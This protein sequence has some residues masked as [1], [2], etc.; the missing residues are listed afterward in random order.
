MIRRFFTGLRGKLILTYTLVTV[1]AL[2]ALEVLAILVVFVPAYLITIDRQQYFSD[3]VDVLYPQARAYLQPGKEDLPG[4]Q[5]W[6]DATYQAGYAS[7][8]AQ[9]ANDSPAAAIVKSDPMVVISPKGIVLAQ[10]PAG[11]ASLVGRQYTPPNT[12]RSQEVLQAALDKNYTTANLYTQTSNGNYLIAVPV[13]AT[14]KQS[15]LVGVIIMTVKPP[16]SLLSTRWPFLA[17]SLPLLVAIVLGTG[18]LLL[19][20]VAPF[21]ALFG[22][23]VSGGLT[24]RLKALTRAADAWSEG[25][26][27][28]QPQ[29]RSQ[30]EIGILGRQMRRMA[31]RVQLLLQSQHE[32]ALMEERNRLARELHDTVKQE[33][34]A[35]LM[36]V[37]AARNL[38]ESD[39]TTARQHLEEAEGL[40]KSSQQELGLI[41]SELRPAALE[42]CGLADALRAYADTWSKHTRIPIEFQVQNECRLSLDAEQAL[43]RIA[44]EALSNVARHSRASAAQLRLEFCPGETQ[45]T[46]SDNGTGFDTNSP[47]AGLGLKSMHERLSTLGGDLQVFSSKEKGTTVKAVLPAEK[48]K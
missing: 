45:L 44:Q 12:S 28:V 33:T 46:I 11:Q 27:T 22:L 41:I 1:L 32:L 37:R 21:G 24:R 13:A 36:Q 48:A 43:Y 26:F 6:L 38:L 16:P 20:A 40:I 31:E 39:P 19:M 2:L 10:A 9:N 5:A 14:D 18:I 34:F 47:K 42:G 3:V 7:L 23:V 8:P 15:Q 4:L 29:D 35:T 30:D 25:N 17:G